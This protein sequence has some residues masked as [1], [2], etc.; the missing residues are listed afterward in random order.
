M[1][2]TETTDG[3]TTELS[4]AAKY[5]LALEIKST[6]PDEAWAILEGLAMQAVAMRD[7]LSGSSKARVGAADVSPEWR[8]LGAFGQGMLYAYVACL[9]TRVN[10]AEY[11]ARR[12]EGRTGDHA[13]QLKRI[14]RDFLNG[15]SS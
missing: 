2:K 3:L 1:T 7:L 8:G 10:Q 13:S 6:R 11:L 9:E 5:K 4:P 15:A 12:I 14:C